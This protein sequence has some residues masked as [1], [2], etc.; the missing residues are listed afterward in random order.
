MNADAKPVPL[1]CVLMTITMGVL[2][3]LLSACPACT[4]KNR[5]SKFEDTSI[6]VSPSFGI[7][8]LTPPEKSDPTV[9]KVLRK[10]TGAQT[11]KLSPKYSWLF[12]LKNS[13][14]EV[15]HKRRG[16]ED[17][18]R[19]HHSGPIG[20]PA[21]S[22]HHPINHISREKKLS[23]FLKLLSDALLRQK[24]GDHYPSPSVLPAK[25][26][27]AF[28]CRSV[29]DIP[30]ESGETMEIQNYHRP[31]SEGSFYRGA[32]LNVTSGR[33]TAPFTGLYLFFAK[34]QIDLQKNP[35]HRDPQGFVH[36]QLCIL[37]LCQE[38][39][40][41][42][43]VGGFISRE[44]TATITLNGVLYIQAG[45]YVSLFFENRIDSWM[46]LVKESDFSGVL[47]GQ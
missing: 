3:V 30:V 14:R 28:T 26:P 17:S 40:S 37:S 24:D 11:H 35:Q 44:D 1:R 18:L 15:K 6:T 20:A 19:N 9:E 39:M 36:L 5:G 12:F 47:L 46:V 25:V 2:L 22:R 43:Q 27:A 41:L 42:Q 34:L 13:D 33:Y 45:Q 38:N 21:P 10:E 4:H 16:H 7:P 23:Q 31:L 8:V 32:G 29:S